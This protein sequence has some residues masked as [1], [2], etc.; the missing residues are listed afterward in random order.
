MASVPRGLP[1]G[2]RR[3]LRSSLG[4]MTEGL[5]LGQALGGPLH[6]PP[7]P[8]AP[9]SCSQ[10]WVL[11]SLTRQIVIPAKLQG[12]GCGFG[13]STWARRGPGREGGVRVASHPPWPSRLLEKRPA[14]FSAMSPS[15]RPLPLPAS[16]SW[17]F[18]EECTKATAVSMNT[19]IHC[20]QLPEGASWAGEREPAWPRTAASC[21]LRQG[22]RL[23]LCPG[24]RAQACRPTSEGSSLQAAPAAL[25]PHTLRPPLTAPR[26]Q[27][28]A[29]PFPCGGPCAQTPLPPGLCRQELPKPC[30]FPS[31]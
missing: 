26:G 2:P 1:G 7:P 30:F 24:S 13:P 9:T 4:E 22:L 18:G 16:S 3:A 14:C 10:P 31:N 28:H 11:Q 20:A 25:I 21:V 29:C 6:H 17:C 12:L 19:G 27:R 23:T 5:G 15:C 8:A